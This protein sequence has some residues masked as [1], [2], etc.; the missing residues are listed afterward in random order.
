M[1]SV[2]YIELAIARE[3]M[4]S[5]I[6]TG[7]AEAGGLLS[8]CYLHVLA[9]NGTSAMHHCPCNNKKK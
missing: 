1:N 5:L 3:V 9:C 6:T 4:S 8:T 7:T 2:G